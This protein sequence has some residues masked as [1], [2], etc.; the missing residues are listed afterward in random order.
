M[1]RLLIAALLAVVWAGVPSACAAAAAI[2]V[3]ANVIRSAEELSEYLATTAKQGSPLD[4][5]PVGARRRFL[6]QLIFGPEGVVAIGPHDLNDT[7]TQPQILEVLALFGL[8]EH[9]E[10]MAGL[11]ARRAPRTFESDFESRY[12]AF[13]ASLNTP[14]GAG[15]SPRIAAYLILLDGNDP[16]KL[17]ATLDHYDQLLLY[18]AMLWVLEEDAVAALP[19][20]ARQMLSMLN[21]HGEDLPRRVL[22]LFDGL[23]EIRRFELAERLLRDYPKSGIPPLPARDFADRSEVPRNMMLQ[24][25][26]DGSKL[27]RTA[28]DLDEGLHIVVVAGCHFAKDAATAIS[29]D[30]A[31]DRLFR[32]HATWLAPDSESI[33]QVADWN[34]ALP[35]QPIQIA[36]R[37]RDWPQIASWAMPTFY[38]FRDGRLLTQWSGWAGDTGKATLVSQLKD[39]GVKY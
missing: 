38:L 36:W 7:L 3:N 21:D 32:E 12:D 8:E 10:N 31:L 35:T 4:A 28:L 15:A 13:T 27:S 23:V 33:A 30:P 29:A 2:S 20:Q 25:S 6:A 26:P 9:G 39:A 17:A 18:R 1:K 16:V 24:V 19:E 14:P 22:D 11:A 34:R 5:M 37:E